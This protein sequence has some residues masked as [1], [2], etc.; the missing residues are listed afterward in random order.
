M[1]D[2]KSKDP[3]AR[4]VGWYVAKINGE[5][6]TFS[7]LSDALRAYDASVVRS[8]G[9]STKESDLN[10]PEDWKKFLSKK[11]KV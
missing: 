5:D 3:W 2:K 7:Q 10:L 9:A 4:L 1:T 8:K 6:R 11:Q